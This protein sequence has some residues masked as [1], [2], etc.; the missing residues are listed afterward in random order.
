MSAPLVRPGPPLRA[1]RGMRGFSLIIALLMLAVIG[2]ASA[3]IMR[4]ATSGD[5]VANGNRL[6][7][8]AHQA[9][10]LALRFCESQS[11]LPAAARRVQAL[12][13]A[14]PPAWTLR[15]TWSAGGGAHAL[16]AADMGSA[17]SVRVA[18]QCVL[19][20]TTAPGVYIVTARGYSA[21]F[22]A[23]AST[24]STR[25]G[26]VVWLQATLDLG[27]ESAVSAGRG[28]DAGRA[29]DAGKG[30]NGGSA[31]NAGNAGNGGN[32]GNGG[33]AANAGN[34]MGA[35]PGASAANAGAVGASAGPPADPAVVRRRLWQQLLTPPF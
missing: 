17:L 21:D 2:L 23:D 16:V 33:S 3:A 18:P 26:S 22:Q 35:S 6:Q 12:P 4:N 19:E 29:A 24:G 9:A 20:A 32:G 15:P 14:T 28:G 7:T 27:G 13:P 1:T 5:Q 10:Q 25:T 8:Q 31:A 11:R 34:A 30:R